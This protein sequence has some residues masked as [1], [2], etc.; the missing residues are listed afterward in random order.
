MPTILCR[1]IENMLAVVKPHRY[2]VLRHWRE[3]DKAQQYHGLHQWDFLI[4]GGD[5]VVAHSRR[6]MNLTKAF[7]GQATVVCAYEREGAGEHVVCT[8]RKAG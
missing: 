8:I 3:E 7:A 4:E 1:V 2:V 5:F 6:N